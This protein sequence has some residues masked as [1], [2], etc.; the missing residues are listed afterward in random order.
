MHAVQLFFSFLQV[1]PQFRWHTD[2]QAGECQPQDPGSNGEPGAPSASLYFPEKYSSDILSTVSMSINKNLSKPGPPAA[3][4]STR[5]KEPTPSSNQPT[6]NMHFG[7][8]NPYS[9]GAPIHLY[10]V[11]Q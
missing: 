11:N 6:G 3:T 10:E 9:L 8:H 7:E 5:S 1:A 4:K 2:F